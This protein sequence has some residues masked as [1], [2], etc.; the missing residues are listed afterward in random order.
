M[1]M[2]YVHL[3]VDMQ[4]FV[5]TKQVSWYQTEQF[6][7]VITHP[8][9]MQSF[10]SCIAKLIQCSALEVYVAVA[11]GGLTCIF[12]GKSWLKA[13]QSFPGV[14][15]A[16]LKQFLSTGLKTFE[17]IQQY[18]DTV[19]LHAGTGWT[20]CSPQNSLSTSLIMQG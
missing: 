12:N 20:N 6:H 5:I 9:G 7:N 2:T 13:M 8:G 15:A 19:H 14:S 4:L 17:Q 18:L 3:S 10:I 11:Y 1:G 16:L